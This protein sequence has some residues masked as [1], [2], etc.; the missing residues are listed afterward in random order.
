M[1]SLKGLTIL[2]VD[3]E[4]ELR[5]I[6][7][8]NLAYFGAEVVGVANGAEAWAEL[9][10][11]YFDV[12]LSDTRMPGGD[13]FEL[14]KRISSDSQLKPL[15]FLVTGYTDL[16]LAEA[17]KYG[18]IEIFTKPFS[19]QNIILAIADNAKKKQEAT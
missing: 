2:V 9:N 8:E 13:G 5:E 19:M 15:L 4:P 1:T 14:I 11:R 18:V 7:M 10:K 17:Q 3:D 6:V 16:S 12:V